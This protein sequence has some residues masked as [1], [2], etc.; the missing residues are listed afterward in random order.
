M[1][2]ATASLQ[3]KQQF[4]DQP[5]AVTNAAASPAVKV[6]S[7]GIGAEAGL[8][9]YAGLAAAGLHSPAQSPIWISNWI[10]EVQP[11]YLIATLERGGQP[12]L[13][14]ALEVVRSGPFRVARFMG[15][16]HAN[17]NFPAMTRAFAASATA[18]DIKGLTEA[19]GRARPDIDMIALERMATDIGGASNPLLMLPHLQSPNVSLAVDLAG[20]FDAMLGRTSGKRKR[21]KHR[22]QTRKFEAA[23]S[24]RRVTA[25]TESEV[26]TL[27]DAFFVMKELRFQKMGVAD[28]FAEPEVKSFF[29]SIFTAALKEPKPSFVLN[30]LEVAGKIRA[31]TGSSLC[32]DRLICEFGAISE[33]DLA[34]AS[35]GEFLFFDNIQQ[36]CQDKFAVYDFSVGD[37]PYKRLWCDLEIRQ[38]DVLVPLTAKGRLLGASMRQV[39]ALKAFIKNNRFIWKLAKTFRKKAAA[40]VAP[41]ED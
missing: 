33:D 41:S 18:A 37:E 8:A 13:A 26:N 10:A 25:A 23:G 32:G 20:G 5:S 6:F 36:A 21:K 38:F 17:G 34:G 31:V 16:R 40:Q 35:P 9:A 19:I 11:D 39:T 22:S 14:V 12:V 3:G 15:G 7:R 24:F 1:V 29:R 27:L 30:A 2:D 28:V 4:F